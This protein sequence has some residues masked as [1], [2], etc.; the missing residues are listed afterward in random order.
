MMCKS[1]TNAVLICMKELECVWCASCDDELAIRI[2]LDGSIR[3]EVLAEQICVDLVC[4]LPCVDVV[5]DDLVLIHF[6]LKNAHLE[7]TDGLAQLIGGCIEL[8]L[9]N[10]MHVE[11]REDCILEC[12]RD[13]LFLCCDPKE[14][15]SLHPLLEGALLVR[16]GWDVALDLVIA[17]HLARVFEITFSDNNEV[18]L[19]AEEFTNFVTFQDHASVKSHRRLAFAARIAVAPLNNDHI[20]PRVRILVPCHHMHTIHVCDDS[21]EYGAYVMRDNYS[22][23]IR[24]ISGGIGR[25][26]G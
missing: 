6:D 11:I 3:H 15:E 20:S 10:A 1:H 5:P 4:G 24:A 17:A 23:L 9:D 8:D 16:L 25:L 2:D 19:V 14:H 26:L 12:R 13:N 22:S 21:R 18:L 7:I